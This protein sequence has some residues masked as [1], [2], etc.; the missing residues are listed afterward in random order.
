MREPIIIDF[1]PRFPRLPLGT[2]KYILLA[3]L[4]LIFILSS[5][6][7]VEPNESGVVLRFGR[8]IKTTGPGPHFK[9]PLIEKVLKVKTDYQFKMEFGFRTKEPGVRTTYIKKGYEGESLMLTGDLNIADVEWVVQYRIEDP[10]KYLFHLYNVPDTLRDVS[11]ACMRAVV[12]DHSFD[13]VIKSKRE[14]IEINV[15]KMMQKLLDLYDVGVQVKLVQLQDVHPPEPVKDSFDEVNRAKQDMERM[16]NEAQ[17]EYNKII[18]RVEGEA[19]KMVEEAEGYAIQRVKEAQGD[20]QWFEHL[21][22]AYRKAPEVTRRRL[23]LET[24]KEVMGKVGQVYVVDAR[25]KTILPYLSL[26]KEKKP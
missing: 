26:Q 12:G 3:I 17:R 22:K 24:L 6:Y 19:K 15:L 20:A 13:E 7:Q 2:I 4:V 16:I 11:E 21:L 14:F 18:F 9:I 1:P 25:Q 23:Y 5:Y 10:K 8:Y